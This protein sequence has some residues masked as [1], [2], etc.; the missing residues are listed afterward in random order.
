MV[1][2]RRGHFT[3]IFLVLLVAVLLVVTHGNFN[4]VGDLP[5]YVLRLVTRDVM[6]QLVR[7]AMHS[8][9]IR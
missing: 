6:Y 5:A 1:R 3:L 8:I 4:F 2:A 7:D 9:H